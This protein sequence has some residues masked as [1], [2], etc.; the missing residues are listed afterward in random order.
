MQQYV[1]KG[2]LIENNAT[3]KVFNEI[4]AIDTTY[5]YQAKWK[6]IVWL[7]SALAS[8]QEN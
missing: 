4:L 5:I 2:E 3:L 7:S 8:W 6:A 1:S